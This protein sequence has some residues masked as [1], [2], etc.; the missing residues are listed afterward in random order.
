MKVCDFMSTILILGYEAFSALLP[1]MLAFMILKTAAKKKGSSFS[2]GRF[3]ALIVFSLY[4]IGVYY[5]TGAGT[6]YD[7]LRFKPELRHTQIN[8]LPFSRDIDIVAYLLNIVLFVPLGL[9]IPLIWKKMNK[10]GRVLGVGFLFT[11]LIELSQLLNHRATDIDDAILNVFGAAVGFGLFKLW[12][13]LTK[14]RFRVESPVTAELFICIFVA[15]AG[16]FLLYN[17]MGLAK[18]IYGF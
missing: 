5:V 18:L 15:F 13:K 4:I 6:L 10:P 12:D 11:L 16:R 1:L 8:L 14:A 17:E 9:L 3:L 2:R 7:G